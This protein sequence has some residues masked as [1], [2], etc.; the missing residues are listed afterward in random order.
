MIVHRRWN[1]GS[2]TKMEE[3]PLLQYISW[4][5]AM[6]VEREKLHSCQWFLEIRVL[7]LAVK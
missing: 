7:L 3:K 2:V 4:V 6:D 5:P 1:A